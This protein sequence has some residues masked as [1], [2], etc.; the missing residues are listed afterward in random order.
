VV[1]LY[2]VFVGSFSMT[3]YSKSSCS[4]CGSV[5]KDWDVASFAIKTPFMECPSCGAINKTTS[6][7]SEWALSDGGAKF[8]HIMLT[9]YWGFCIGLVFCVGI[10]YVAMEIYP[11]LRDIDV[12]SVETLFIVVPGILL[13]W[14]LNFTSLLREIRRS[15]KR[16]SD[17]DYVNKLRKLGFIENN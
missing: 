2:K 4:R 6:S 5:L 11:S 14:L 8:Q 7:G 16:M 17:P 15:K 10:G 12:K 13:G 3:V 1:A 9:I